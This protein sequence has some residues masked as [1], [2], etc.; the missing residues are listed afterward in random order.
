M[1]AWLRIMLRDFDVSILV[2]KLKGGFAAAAHQHVDLVDRFGMS[3]L[4]LLEIVGDFPGR[5]LGNKVKRRVRQCNRRSD[6]PRP[7]SRSNKLEPAP[8]RLRANC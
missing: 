6:P 3:L 1:T 8:L 2:F 4:F 7:R 5:G